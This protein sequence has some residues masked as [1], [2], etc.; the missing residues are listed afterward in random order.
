M[1]PDPI[2]SVCFVQIQYKR[3]MI[4]ELESILQNFNLLILIFM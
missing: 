2:V 3:F 1:H 4:T